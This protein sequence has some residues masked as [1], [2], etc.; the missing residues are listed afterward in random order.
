MAERQLKLAFSTNVAGASYD[1]DTQQLTVSF[2]S[3]GAGYYSGVSSEEAG[4]FERSASPGR[5]VHDYLKPRFPWT[6]MA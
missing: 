4:E 2:L 3:G 1:V 5:Y 6:K